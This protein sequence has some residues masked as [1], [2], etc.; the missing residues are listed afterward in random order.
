VA[1]AGACVLRRLFMADRTKGDDMSAR[2]TGSVAVVT[3]ILMGR[4]SEPED[5]AK[6][7]SY[8]AS[9]A[10]DYMTGQTVLIDGGIQFS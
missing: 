7:V 5:V 9:P 10:S 4:V 2:I 8:L 3:S 6:L 1:G